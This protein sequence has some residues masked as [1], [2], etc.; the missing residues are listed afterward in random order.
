MKRPHITFTRCTICHQPWDSICRNCQRYLNA[1]QWT[2][3]LDDTPYLTGLVIGRHYDRM[4]KHLVHRLKYGRG[5][6]I[7]QILWSKLSTLIYTTDLIDQIQLHPRQVIVTAVP[8]HR[9]KRYCTRWYNQAE[10]LA[11]SIAQ[12]LELPYRELLRKSRRT[13]SQVKVSRQHRLDNILNSFASSLQSPHS[14]WE[15]GRPEGAGGEVIILVDDIIT[16]GATINECARVLHQQ[17]PHAQIW[18]ICIAR[19]R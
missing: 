4:I 14:P 17:Y 10:L 6:H 19:N 11:R 9:F 7:A 13:T 18:W 5:R 12:S 16:T 15:G 1:Y 2:V 3:D 8:T